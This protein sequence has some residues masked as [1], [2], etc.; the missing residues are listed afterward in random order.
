MSAGKVVCEVCS[1]RGPGARTLAAAN[2][3]DENEQIRGCPVCKAV[4][5]FRAAC[6]QEGCWQPVTCGTPTAD[7]YRSTCSRHQ[8]DSDR[9]ARDSEGPWRG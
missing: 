7:G 8:P 2:P 9:R 6:D 1:W 5:C 4:E 3:F